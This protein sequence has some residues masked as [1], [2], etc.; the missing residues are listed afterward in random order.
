MRRKIAS[1]ALQKTPSNNSDQTAHL[2]SLIRIF[3]GCMSESTFSD[4]VTHLYIGLITWD[5]EGCP[6]KKDE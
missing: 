6:G 5:S 3:A 1:L 2:H 4:V